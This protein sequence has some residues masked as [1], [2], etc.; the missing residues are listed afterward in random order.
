MGYSSHEKYS[1]YEIQNLDFHISFANQSVAVGDYDAALKIYDDAIAQRPNSAELHLVHGHAL[2]TIGDVEDAL[3]Q[4]HSELEVL[5]ADKRDLII[6]IN[7]IILNNERISY[8]YVALIGVMCGL[9]TMTR[10]DFVLAGM[11]VGIVMFTQNIQFNS[12]E[13]KFS[14]LNFSK[15]IT[16]YVFYFITISPW[17]I[18]SFIRFGKFFTSDNSANVLSVKF[19]HP[20]TFISETPPTIFNVPFEWLYLLLSKIKGFAIMSIYELSII[21]T[22]FFIIILCVVLYSLYN[23]SKII[24]LSNFLNLSFL[25]IS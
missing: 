6:N 19:I 13:F 3:A 22:P 8:L 11:V 2:K 20:L 14:S 4:F 25:I 15:S 17:I 18:H 5:T 9:A 23:G 10:F 12:S 21:T 24:E 16:Y 7:N 1:A